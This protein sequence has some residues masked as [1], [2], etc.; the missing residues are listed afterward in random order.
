M[1]QKYFRVIISS[2]A[3]YACAFIFSLRP[4]FF[5]LP[6]RVATGKDA[7][8]KLL[9]QRYQISLCA[10]QDAHAVTLLLQGLGWV[11]GGFKD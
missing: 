5:S 9:A 10:E 4:A 11:K 8:L 3:D 7:I 1:L 2:C 6:P